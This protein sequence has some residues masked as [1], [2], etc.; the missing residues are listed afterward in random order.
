VDLRARLGR[1]WGATVLETIHQLSRLL[2]RSS[3]GDPFHQVR[4]RLAEEATRH[5]SQ[6][7]LELGARNS[8]VRALVPPSM[9]YV[10]FDIR[11]GP[12]VDVVG[13]IHELARYFDPESFDIVCAI[14]T[15]EHLAM[16]WKAVLEINKVLR[17]GGLLFV[18]TH[19]TWP[20]HE[21]PWDFWRF[22]AEAFRVLLGPPTG[23]ELI[24]VA[25]GLPCLILP[26]VQEPAT[27][28]MHRAQGN[29]GVSAL[30]RKTG[31]TQAGLC[32]DVPVAD[33]LITTYPPA[34]TRSPA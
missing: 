17:P 14:A 27:R 28:D 12:D 31:P 23:F 11:P 32:W 16:P 29:L 5:D 19:P 15:F 25:E 8:T 1:R 22:S 6:N 20:P 13:D 30:A 7:V 33:I 18:V 26:L 4:Q 9:R 21:L 34:A 3:A 24:T 2:V 10:G